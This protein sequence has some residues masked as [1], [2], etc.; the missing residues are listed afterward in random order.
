LLPAAG[1]AI[2]CADDQIGEAVAVDVAG[3]GHAAAAVV[4][5]ALAVDDEAAVAGGDRRQ[6]DGAAAALAEDQIAAPGVGAMRRM[7]IV[8]P[9]DQVGEAVAV[10]VAGRRDTVAT[11]V[12]G[13]LAVDDE[14]AAAVGDRREVDGV[15]CRSCRRRRS[16]ARPG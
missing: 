14:A 4:A 13:T 2:R 15:S 10:E 16:C 9:D 3:S 7:A 11:G 8:R 1:V 12:V 5:G 6:L